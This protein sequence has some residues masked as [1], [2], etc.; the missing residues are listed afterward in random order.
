MAET[1]RPKLIIPVLLEPPHEL[2]RIPDV[3]AETQYFDDD[4]PEIYREEGLRYMFKRSN[5]ELKNRYQD[6]LDAL[7]AKLLA[8]TGEQ[9]LPP[10]AA[11]PDIKTVQSAFHRPDGD[12]VCAAVSSESSGPRYA[13]FV[14]VAGKREEI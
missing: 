2:G 11:L 10:L 8:A 6:F 5:N 4:Y 3:L 1:E 14:Y 7:V 13:D 12:V 9:S